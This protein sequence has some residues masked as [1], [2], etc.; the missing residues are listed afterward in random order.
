M[1]EPQLTQRMTLHLNG[2]NKFS[3]LHYEVLANGEPTGVT[4]HKYTDGSPN[5]KYTGFF[6]RCGD[7]ELDVLAD[8]KTNIEEW[9]RARIAKPTDVAK[10]VT[11]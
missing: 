7:E 3:Q 9:I 8:R 4:I 10:A 1:S 5:Y 2:G 11:S 6:V